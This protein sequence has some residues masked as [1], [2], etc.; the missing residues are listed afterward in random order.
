MIQIDDKII[1]TDLLTEPFCCDPSACRGA[2]CVEGNG[3][4]PLDMDEVDRLEEEYEAYRPYLKP[5]GV[6]AIEEQGF[7]TVEP[8]G[9]YATPLINH[10][11]CA[12][13]FEENGCTLCAIERAAHEGRTH[14]LKPL[15][16]HLYPIRV[17]RFG[18]GTLGLNYHRWNICHDACVKG[19]MLG[20]PV[21]RALREPIVRAFGEEFFRALE[22]AER[23]LKE[24]SATDR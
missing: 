23:L 17:M 16:C 10:A 18:N 7:M 5:E 1:S 24:H 8:D 12:Y 19:E 4:A 11:E 3:G 21:Y 9:E 22:E 2:C 14:F 20:I 13:S 6:R 15:S